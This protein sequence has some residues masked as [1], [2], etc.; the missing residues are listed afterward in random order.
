MLEEPSL[1][2]GLLPSLGRVF[3]AVSLIAF[4][5]QQFLFGDVVPGRAP[6][7]PA[8]VPGRLLFAYVSGAVFIACGAAIILRRG[9]RGAA[10]V[11]GTMI[12]AWALLRHIPLAIAD[13]GYGL[14]W[15]NLGKS[16][17]LFGGALAV[18]GSLPEEKRSF[19][20]L[21]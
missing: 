5:T 17:A 19:L 9:G 1:E 11:S 4:G 16:V 2:V 13:T 3:F 6:A 20:T 14:A 8:S 18:A 15:T 7:W 12:F 10:I 21:G